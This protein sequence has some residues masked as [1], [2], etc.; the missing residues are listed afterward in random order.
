VTRTQPLNFTSASYLGMRHPPGALG[1]WHRLTTGVPAALAEPHLAR[2]VARALAGL[3]GTEDAVLA[4]STLHAFWDLFVTLGADRLICYV[5]ASTYPI[6]GWGVERA[7]ARGALTER[8]PHR[9]VTALRRLLGS[10]RRAGRVPLVVTDGLCPG[11]GLAAPLGRYL[12]ALGPLGGLLVVDD[13]QALGILGR[14]AIAYP[15]YGRGGG[16]TLR[17]AELSSPD[18]LVVSSLAK[19]FGVPVAIIGGSGPLVRQYALRSET[20]VHTSPPSFAH[21]RAAEHACDVNR[22]DGD[23]RRARLAALVRRLQAG[24]HD[25]GLTIGPSGFPVQTLGPVDGIPPATLHKRLAERGVRAVLHRPACQRATRCSF[26][27]TAGHTPEQID[28]AIGA[29]G[30][31]VARPA[32]TAATAGTDRWPARAD[33]LLEGRRK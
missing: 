26:L 8:F 15:P 21:L 30:R 10:P 1:P 12:R 31:A 25:L 5:D 11:C 17:T 13:T 16:G 7:V 2:A 18:V 3:V 24:V 19:G 22:Q 20:R 28:R 4:T 23:R 29:L 6:A 14:D 9:D 33:A 27:V 32:A